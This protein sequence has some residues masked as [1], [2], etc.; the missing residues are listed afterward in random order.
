[1]NTHPKSFL[2]I[3]QTSTNLDQHQLCLLDT[4][5]MSPITSSFLLGAFGL[6]FIVSVTAAPKPN[7]D[8][9]QPPEPSLGQAAFETP[10]PTI[11]SVPEPAVGQA[12]FET[13]KPSTTPVSSVPE[14]SVGQPKFQ[15]AKPSSTVSSVPEPSFGQP[16]FTENKKADKTPEPTRDG[17][18]PTFHKERPAHNSGHGRHHTHH[19]FPIGVATSTMVVSM[20]SASLA[21]MIV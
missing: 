19:Q 21:K 12:S 15:P 5:N 20:V 2:S 9:Q 11:S 13:P 1:M 16:T 4:T 6:L 8:P 18:Q 7:A 10:K 17:K 3:N 14:P